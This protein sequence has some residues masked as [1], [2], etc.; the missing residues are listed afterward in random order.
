M[1]FSAHKDSEQVREFESDDTTLER[2]AAELA[3]LIRQSH[4]FIAF[5][6]AGVSTSAGIPDFRGPQGVW[7]LRAKGEFPK[8]RQSTLSA[9]P[10]TGH[11]ALIGLERA[12]LLKFLISQNTDGL[13]RRSGF[14]PEKLAELHGNSNLERCRHCKKEYLR[15]FSTRSA[16]GVHDHQTTRKCA[17]CGHW[18][19]DTIINFSESLPE[20]PLKDGFIN[21]RRADLCLVLGS[22]LTI[23]IESRKPIAFKVSF[24]ILTMHETL[25]TEFRDTNHCTNESLEMRSVNGEEKANFCNL[26]YPNGNNAITSC[27]VFALQRQLL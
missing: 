4:H 8:S 18:L 7:T 23:F 20:K 14:P 16:P 2:Q 11:M 12:G 25:I 17:V 5:T 15:D 21:A 27:N 3:N 13:H 22:S 1:A 26:L 19:H 9:V 6:G 24:L 10:T